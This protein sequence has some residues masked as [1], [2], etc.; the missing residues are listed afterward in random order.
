MVETKIQ[1]YDKKIITDNVTYKERVQV[2][3]NGEPC[4]AYE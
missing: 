3:A 1:E 2:D 4:K